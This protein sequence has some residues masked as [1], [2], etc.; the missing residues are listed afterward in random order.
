MALHSLAGAWSYTAV[1][2]ACKVRSSIL[3]EA[4]S[5]R[6][7]GLTL[8]ETADEACGVND[9]LPR[10]Q[11]TGWYTRVPHNLQT[12]AAE[13]ADKDTAW[14]P[15]Q[16]GPHDGD[17]LM[18]VTVIRPRRVSLSDPEALAGRRFNCNLPRLQLQVKG[19]RHPEPSP[20]TLLGGRIRHVHCQ[21]HVTD[22]QSLEP[23]HNIPMILS[24][25]LV[26]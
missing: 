10:T 22:A 26:H 19:V 16:G 5:Q 25:R 8:W 17:T 18:A 7:G 6:A 4:C 2:P 24:Q 14:M 12:L 1:L 13:H 3:H 9:Q 11:S 20:D 15:R 23:P 21:P